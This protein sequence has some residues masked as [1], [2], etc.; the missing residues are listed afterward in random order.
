MAVDGSGNVYV[1]DS[2][3]HRIR[4]ITASGIVTTLAGSG[5]AGYA[6]GN[7][8]SASFYQALGV[9]VDG[10]ENVYVADAVNNRIRKIT[11]S[12]TVTTLA[13]SGSSGYADGNGASAIFYSPHAVAVDGSGN[14]YVADTGNHR[15]RNIVPDTDGDGLSD[16][17][18]VN[19]Y[20]TDPKKAD[21][22]GDG[23]SDGAE[24]NAYRTDPKKAD[25]DGD[26]LSD[27]A[28]V[29]TYGTDPKKADADGDGLS[30]GAEVNTYGTDPKKADTDG[31]GL[32]D[33]AE[34]NTYGTDPKK[35]DTDGDGLSDWAEISTHGTDPKKADTDGDGLSDGEEDTDG[36][37]LNDG[38]EI[39]TYGTD[40]KKADTDKDGLSDRE[41][42]IMTITNPKN[43]DSD[44]DGLNDGA[45][46]TD[47]DGLSNLAEIN[48]TGSNPKNPDTDGD[49][50]NDGA[51]DTDGDSLSD[52]AEINTYG[53]DSKKG[54]TDGDSLSDGAEINTHGTDPKNADMDWDSL[55]DGVEINTH[56]TDPKNADTD[57]D[58]HTDSFEI[59]NLKSSP[60][61]SNDVPAF[62]PVGNPKNPD[63]DN[64]GYDVENAGVGYVGQEYEIGTT[65][66]SNLMY[67]RFLNAIAKNDTLYG[68]YNTN[69]GTDA[70]GGIVRAGA[71]GNYSYTVKTGFENRPVNFVSVYDTFR[72][73]NWLHNGMPATGIQDSSTTENGAYKLLG[74]N[75]R[76]VVR[77]A[78]AKFFL[79]DQDEWHKAAFFD[80]DP[81][82]GRPSD[83]YWRYADQTTAASHY[84]TYDQ[85]GNVWEWT[86]T[87]LTDGKRLI[88][89]GDGD[90]PMESAMTTRETAEL[91]FRVARPISV[92]S[93]PPLVVPF[94]VPVGEEFNLGDDTNGN[95]GAVVYEYQMG[96]YEITN[97]EYQTF[98]NAVA[99]TDSFYGFY[100]TQMGTA[101]N[102]GIMRSGQNG[103]F[104]YTVKPGFAKK[105]VNFVNIYNAMRFCNW[106]HNGAQ[107]NGDTEAGAYRLLGNIP[108][109]TVTLR[110]N[111]SARYFI[112]TED[113]WYKVAF[114]DP[115]PTGMP[116]ASYWS[117][118]TKS[119][120]ASAAMNFGGSYLG[121]MD[122]DALPYPSFFKTYGQSGNVAEW[123]ET[124]VDQFRIVRGGHYS[125]NAQG[126][127]SL[128]KLE[129]D[130]LT[131]TA[132]VG[133]RVAAAPGV[134]SP[135]E[136][137][138]PSPTPKPDPVQPPPG[139]GNSPGGGAPSGG[140]GPAQVQKS[141][142][143]GGKSSAKK[144][145]GSAS[146]KSAASKSTGGKKSG[147]KKKKK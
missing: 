56:G 132:N 17:A 146:K 50:L 126:V 68:L 73:I 99:K 75:P 93:N 32:S 98:L 79:P 141:K 134:A 40:P 59:L 58:S 9:A 80:P 133:F 48:T 43:A 118:A 38:A 111:A 7:G 11:P 77:N 22:D 121:P 91:G 57:G 94:L 21:T 41:E 140:S 46:D 139:G 100:N 8:A 143:G 18:E 136:T 129:L 66:I 78:G 53:T 101:A 64:A 135:L 52:G 130:P 71:N 120:S 138:G 25:T 108:N 127:S 116:T 142:K 69:M 1:A 27:G 88:S 107:P 67:A 112:P 5:S 72:Y 62:T 12:G 74:A 31:D 89:Q 103:N 70:S 23:L 144:S 47:G 131:T 65:E 81:G 20:G 105:P 106:L 45:E 145:S 85:G 90:R 54:D 84:G 113:E 124:V 55:S 51:E 37:G 137:V 102:G 87:V 6:D 104:N 63:E 115:S 29:N 44:G 49:G 122:I 114:Y 96:T 42:V 97:A 86:E 123:T 34:V 35:A 82:Q 76:N 15:I 24:A 60:L 39:N 4:K 95:R 110:R 117:H 30:D 92:D 13:G 61:A 19:T 33:G 3:N 26:G 109:N 147:G 10:S 2:G 28:E 125:S 36:D 16:G 128:G 119:D 14:V 83:S